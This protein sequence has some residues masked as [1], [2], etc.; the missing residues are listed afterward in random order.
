MKGIKDVSGEKKKR[1]SGLRHGKSELLKTEL[2]KGA[3]EAGLWR[4][5]GRWGG[6]ETENSV[7]DVFA[8]SIQPPNEDAEYMVGY[9]SLY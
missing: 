9:M 3:V 2:G 8:M 5:A 1:V 4:E 6:T 7:W